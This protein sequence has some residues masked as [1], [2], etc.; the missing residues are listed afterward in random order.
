MV[1]VLRFLVA[2]FL[3]AHVS[4]L[5]FAEEDAVLPAAST[6]LDRVKAANE[7]CLQQTPSFTTEVRIIEHKKAIGKKVKKVRGKKK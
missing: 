1:S 4:L 7:L 6:I 5:A 3:C 2:L